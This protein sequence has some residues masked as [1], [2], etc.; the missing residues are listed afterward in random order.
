MKRLGVG[1]H[2]YGFHWRAARDRHPRARFHDAPSFLE[3]CHQLGAG[4]VQVS[5]GAL[6]P[7][8]IR[9]FRERVGELGLYFEA[10]TSLPKD[11]SD[12]ARFEAEARTAVEAGAD[13][14]R[15]AALSGRRYEAFDSMEAFRRFADSAWRSLTLAEPI[16]RKHRLRLAVEN[17]KDWMIEELVGMLRQLSSEHVGALVDT[18]NS[19]ALLEAPMAVVEAYAPFA[20][21]TH[22]KD[23]AVTECADGF[24]LSE[25]RL[26]DGFLDLPK[27]IGILERANPRIRW[28][29]EM[30]TREPL[31]VPCLTPKYWS[32]FQNAT[33]RRLAEALATVRARRSRKALPSVAGLNLDEQLKL[34]NDHVR[35]S[36]EYARAHL[37]L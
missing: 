19:I 5:L 36:L 16:V 30:I 10:Q 26:G 35:Q 32:T 33:A 14:I 4:G 9:R 29:L 15:T 21:S 20:L 8:D 3:H 27:I 6:K 1:M 34:E 23:M 25:V 2:S 13:V 22:L 7:E 37:G 28:N 11:E 18:G 12:A 24:L 31:R 17:H